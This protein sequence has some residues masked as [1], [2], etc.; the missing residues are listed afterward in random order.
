[1]GASPIRIW[2]D[3]EDGGEL[4]VPLDPEKRARV[5][6]ILDEF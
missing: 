4:Y 6:E 2:A 3:A 1:M 5:L